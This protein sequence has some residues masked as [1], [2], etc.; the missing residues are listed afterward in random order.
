MSITSDASLLLVRELRAL[1]REILLFP[2]DTLLWQSLPSITNSAGNLALH[3]AG[4]L[5]HFLGLAIG[6]IPYVRDREQE[7]GRRTGTREEVVAE[8]DAAIVAVAK[9]V[10]DTALGE[11]FPDRPGGHR[12]K[13]GL[14]LMHLCTHTAYHLGQ[15]GYLRRALTGDTRI[16]GALSLQDISIP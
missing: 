10:T 3:V 6:H 15:V 1:Q 16:S 14:F 11:E 8:L 13:A 2:D 4:N 7:F 5:R 9:S 12:I